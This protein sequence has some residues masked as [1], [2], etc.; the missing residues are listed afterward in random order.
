[1]N[2]VETYLVMANYSSKYVTPYMDDDYKLDYFIED[3]GINAYY[4]YMRQM[5]PFWMPSSKYSMPKEIRGQLYYFF[6]QQ[7]LARYFLERMSNGLGKIE[8]FDWNKPIYPGYYS[9]MTYPNGV[10]FP[11]RD[12]FSAIPYYKYKYLKVSVCSTNYYFE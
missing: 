2:N 7:L 5:F 6:H 9:T 1:M 11:Q 4:Y 10:H 8:D 12:K 3:I